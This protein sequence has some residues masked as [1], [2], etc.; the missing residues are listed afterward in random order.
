MRTNSVSPSRS[1]N[2]SLKRPLRWLLYGGLVMVFIMVGLILAGLFYQT[3]SSS[4]DARRYPPPG[5]MVI[6]GPYKMHMYCT[7]VKQPDTPTVILDASY[8][9]TVSSWVWIQPQVAA[10]TR[11]C[12]YDRLGAGWSDPSLAVPTLRQMS[13]DLYAL[14]KSSGES[15]PYL[16]VGHSWGGAVTYLLAD[17]H[18]EEISGLVWIE[19]L[20]AD[21]WARRGVA[22]STLGGMPAEQVA[23]IPILARLGIFRLFPALRGPWGNVPG[24]P[25]QQQAELTSYFNSTLWANHIAAVEKAVPISL[26]Q[27]RKAGSLGDIPLAVVIGSASNEAEEIGLELQRELE[28]LSTNSAEFIITGAD[29]SSL[30]HDQRYAQQT[31]DVILLM[32]AQTANTPR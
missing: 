31:G 29:H 30:V 24:L 5:E 2:I 7:G 19:S 17:A 16:L 27:L 10:S 12:A 22:E 6:V 21:A 25:E 20:H 11:V 18:P 23:G 28:A 14:L 9:A 26:E 3:L 1:R 8:P 32:I 15:G 13:A 4:I